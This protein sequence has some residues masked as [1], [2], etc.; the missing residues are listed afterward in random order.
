M[1]SYSRAPSRAQPRSPA[2]PGPEEAEAAQ[3]TF[4]VFVFQFLQ[5]T[6]WRVFSR[7]PR[8]NEWRQSFPDAGCQE[9]W[10]AFAT[11]T[12]RDG[13]VPRTEGRG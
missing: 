5:V 4:P 12:C 9:T 3:L 8:P 11:W 2:P 7:G 13:Q 6:V 1:S 10:R